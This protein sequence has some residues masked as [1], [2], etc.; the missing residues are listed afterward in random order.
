MSVVYSE[1]DAA[2]N[3][4]QPESW[5]AQHPFI[6]LGLAGA[7]AI[8]I[9]RIFTN[10]KS[11]S[12]SPTSDTVAPSGSN[13]TNAPNGVPSTDA[14]GNPIYYVPTSDTFLN[15]NYTADSYNTTQTTNNTTNNTATTTTTNSNNNNSGNTTTEHEPAPPNQGSPPPVHTTPPPTKP[16][17][18]SPPPAQTK[19]SWT[20]RYTVVSGDTLSAIATRYKTTWPTIYSHNITE[21]NLI[22]GLMHEIIP[23]G[24]WNN[25]RPGEV[26]I[27]PCL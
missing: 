2:D 21:I 14:S 10:Q 16:P 4:Q 15:Y 24:P 13:T 19:G 6:T 1:Q 11:S 23:G 27:V 8:I 17:V 3:G 9:M 26:L 20:C 18:V 5:F 12:T 25:I 22:A 7:V